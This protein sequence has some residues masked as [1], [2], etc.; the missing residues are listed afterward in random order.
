MSEMNLRYRKD[1][2]LFFSKNRLNKFK[3]TVAAVCK[4]FF[5]FY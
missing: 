1:V 4:S 2:V 5:F 3:P